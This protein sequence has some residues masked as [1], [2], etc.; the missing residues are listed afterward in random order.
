MFGINELIVISTISKVFTY[1][2]IIVDHGKLTAI[3]EYR[4]SPAYSQYLHP[5]VVCPYRLGLSPAH[6]YRA[7]LAWGA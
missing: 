1:Q 2:A 6:H 5:Q 4:L 3:L 7:V